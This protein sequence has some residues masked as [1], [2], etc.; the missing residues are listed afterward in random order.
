MQRRV[1][2]SERSRHQRKSG[3]GHRWWHTHTH[4]YCKHNYT[5][6][7]VTL[8]FTDIN[9][10]L[11]YKHNFQLH[12]PLAPV[13][14]YVHFYCFWPEANALF[15]CTVK[16]MAHWLSLPLSL[17]LSFSLTLSRSGQRSG[18]EGS[19][20]LSVEDTGG[21]AVWVGGLLVPV[22][23]LELCWHHE[24]QPRLC[25]H[26]LSVLSVCVCVC[27]CSFRTNSGFGFIS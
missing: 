18:C 19:G 10:T 9:I 16:N 26:R 21:G 4:L 12:N 23:R 22:C 1:G 5:H 25:S 17:S 8:Y 27:A 15:I 24:E 20:H 3:P 13:A 7:N 11:N 14:F 6:C 2:E